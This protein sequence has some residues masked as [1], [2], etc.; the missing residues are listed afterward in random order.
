M[1]KGQLVKRTRFSGIRQPVSSALRQQWNKTAVVVKG[2]YEKQV[3][4][5][6]AAGITVHTEV[7]LCIDI[8]VEGI[9]IKGLKASDF[10][11]I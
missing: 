4:H 8:L 6:G 7:I 11:R 2:P 10:E 1:R 3:H 9:L 5:T